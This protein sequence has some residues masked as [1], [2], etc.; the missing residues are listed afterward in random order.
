M[1]MSRDGGRRWLCRCDCGNEVSVATGS[2]R[3]G[4]TQSCGCL[5]RE[6]TGQRTR[7]HG[8]SRKSGTYA[9]WV[10]MRDRCFCVTDTSYHRYGGRGITVC[11]RWSSFENFLADMGERPPGMTIDRIDNNGPYSPENCRW[12]TNLE[13]S[14]NKRTSILITVGS[15]TLCLSEWADRT[16][17]DYWTLHGRIRRGWDPVRVVTT[18][19]EA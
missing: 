16:G 7:T 1:A 10:G 17:I 14:R 13:Q 3:C 18:P 11:E 8:L 12:A 19:K 15:E 2:L 5:R 4:E 9:V 6:I